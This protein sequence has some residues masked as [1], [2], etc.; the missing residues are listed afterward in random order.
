MK[1]NQKAVIAFFGA[2]LLLFGAC[3]QGPKKDEPTEPEEVL[4]PEGIISLEESKSLYDNYTKN[5]VGVI[6]EYEMERYPDRKHIPARFTSF[7]YA[8]IKD[9]MAYV[10]QEAKEAG[11][12]VASL[13]LYFANYPDKERFP[14]GKKVVHPRQ[15]SIF[16]VPTTIIDGKELG[17]YIGADGK[18]KPIKGVVGNSETGEKDGPNTSQ[19][20]F[21]PSLFQDDIKSLNL[22]HGTSG[23]PP[24]TDF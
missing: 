20:G 8:D 6:E 12:E 13:R 17:F 24:Y 22:N 9:Y 18:A 3:Q 23:P 7:S 15:N 2:T 16:L 10:E 4:P 19:A 11:V 1:N 14:D 5:R 21:A